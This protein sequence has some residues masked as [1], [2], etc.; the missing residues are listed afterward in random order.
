LRHSPTRLLNSLKLLNLQDQHDLLAGMIIQPYTQQKPVIGVV[1]LAIT[2][3][4]NGSVRCV[5]VA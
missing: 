2:G 4:L 1:V 3:A 5:L